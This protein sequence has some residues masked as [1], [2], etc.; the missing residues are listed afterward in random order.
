MAFSEKSL[1]FLFEN[2]MHDSRAWYQE[3]KT[4]YQQSVAQPC[5][6]LIQQVQPYLA[7]IDPQISCTPRCMSRIYRD[8]RFPRIKACSA[9]ASGVPSVDHGT[10]ENTLLFTLKPDRRGSLTAAAFITQAQC[11]CSCCGK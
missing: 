7:Q 1:A 11:K 10:G 2:R 9:P 4:Q 8:T 6:A 5:K 3:H